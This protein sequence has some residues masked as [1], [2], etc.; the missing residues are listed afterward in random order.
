M[1]LAG[2]LE[3]I[4]AK[5]G[6]VVESYPEDVDGRTVSTSFLY[7]SRLSMFERQGFQRAA[8]LGKNHWVVSRTVTAKT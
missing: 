4:A 1:A 5:G 8:R 3:L 7:N 6:G 2:A